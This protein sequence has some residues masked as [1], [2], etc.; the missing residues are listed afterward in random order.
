[1]KRF[2]IPTLTLLLSI[3]ALDASA[4]GTL[5]HCT[6]AEIAERNLTEKAK[7]NIEKYT[8]GE[9]LSSYAMWMDHIGKDPV[10]GRTAIYQ[11]YKPLQG[12][13]RR[14]LRELRV[15]S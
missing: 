1:M 7:A 13:R 15:E 3:I 11:L 6:I 8:K 14:I 9:P 4:W 10:L 5:G 12:V 2:F